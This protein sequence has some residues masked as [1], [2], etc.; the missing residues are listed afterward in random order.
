MLEDGPMQGSRRDVEVLE[1][2]PPETLD[3]AVD[4]GSESDRTSVVSKRAGVATTIE[5]CPLFAC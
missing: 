5:G 3:L 1:G 2:R 4:D